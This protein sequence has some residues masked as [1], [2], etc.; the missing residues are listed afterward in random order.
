MFQAL[1]PSERAK[2]SPAAA[3]FSL[4][5]S[6]TRLRSSGFSPRTAAMYCP[7]SLRAWS[8]LEVM[9]TTRRAGLTTDGSLAVAAV[10]FLFGPAL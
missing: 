4:V 10:L 2:T 5:S 8:N 6:L 3:P 9:V 1:P 7:W